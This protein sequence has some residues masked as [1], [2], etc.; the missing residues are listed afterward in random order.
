MWL[1]IAYY[2]S[3]HPPA[4]SPLK[5]KQN[6]GITSN[7]NA[8]VNQ[9]KKYT[10]AELSLHPKMQYTQC[11]ICHERDSIDRHIFCIFIPEAGKKKCCPQGRGA[12]IFTIVVTM[13]SQLK[14]SPSCLKVLPKLPQ[15]CLKI[16]SKFNFISEVSKF[17]SYPKKPES[18]QCFPKSCPKAV[19]V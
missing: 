14:L 17:Q 8:C 13:L 16:V 1:S 18:C 19:K 11:P 7:P 12:P 10:T 5:T 9:A 6:M 4:S 15:S 2:A 3:H